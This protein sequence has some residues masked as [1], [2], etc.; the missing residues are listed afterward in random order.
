MAVMIRTFPLVGRLIPETRMQVADVERFKPLREGLRDLE[1]AGPL[2]Q[3]ETLF[4][5]RADAPLGI[6]V[7]FRVVVAGEGLRD[8]QLS[9]GA[10]PLSFNQSGTFSGNSYTVDWALDVTGS[11]G[12]GTTPDAG[13]E[14]GNEGIFPGGHYTP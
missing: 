11:A 1:G 5:E 14:G 4:L 10:Y 12:F 2:P 3:P 7:A 6:G 8:P 9:T 13:A